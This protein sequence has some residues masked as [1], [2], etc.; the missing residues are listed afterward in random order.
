MACFDKEVNET[1]IKAIAKQHPYYFVLRDASLATDQVADN[2]EQIWEEYS[3]ETI[4][5]II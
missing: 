1:A 5:K 3:K 2:F 4:R